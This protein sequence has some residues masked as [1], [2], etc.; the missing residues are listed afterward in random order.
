MRQLIAVGVMLMLAG[1][2]GL[3]AWFVSVIRRDFRQRFQRIQQRV[4]AEASTIV[5]DLFS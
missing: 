2:G 4:E 1:L 3:F 5:R